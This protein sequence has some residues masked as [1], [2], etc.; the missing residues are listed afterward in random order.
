[1]PRFLD[2]IKNMEIETPPDIDNIRPQEQIKV[3]GYLFNGSGN[4]NN[5]INAICSIIGGLFH[6]AYKYR[7]LMPQPARKAFVHANILSRVNYTLRFCAGHT[8]KN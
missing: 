7:R 6:I 5:Q 1:M 4:M 8:N 2:Q 3:L